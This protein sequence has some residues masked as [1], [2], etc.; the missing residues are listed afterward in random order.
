MGQLESRPQRA[1]PSAAPGRGNQSTARPQLSTA[2]SPPDQGPWAEHTGG[3]AVSP[4]ALLMVAAE[5]RAQPE[6]LPFCRA[7]PVALS[8][9]G[10]QAQSSLIWD[11]KH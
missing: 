4:A 11:P 6:V 9:Q 10:V 5:C 7:K 2:F 1:L 8:S 3:G